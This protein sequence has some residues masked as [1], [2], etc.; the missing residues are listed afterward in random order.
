METTAK[1]HP[2][3]DGYYSISGAKTWIT[4]SPI[5]DLL[6]VWAKLQET[7]KIRGFSDREGCL[8]ARYDGDT[9]AGGEERLRAS[10]TGMIQLDE[11]PVPKENCSRMSKD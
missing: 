5:A 10:I 3:K 8:P 2:S 7:G 9:E 6:L 11:C 4:N 1:P